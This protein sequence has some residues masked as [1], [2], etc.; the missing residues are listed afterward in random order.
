[1]A[2]NVPKSGGTEHNLAY[3]LVGRFMFY[4]AMLESSLNSG[5]E[6]LLMLGTLEGAI[7]TANLQF[8]SKIHILKTLMHL[9]CVE[10]DWRSDALS[11]L[12]R[13][14]TVN[15]HWRNTI[16]HVPFISAEDGVQFLRVKAKGKLDFPHTHWTRADFDNMR[17]EVI[18]LTDRVDE[19]V[20]A[21]AKQQRKPTL[22]DLAALATELQNEQEFPNYLGRLAPAPPGSQP[23]NPETAPETPQEPRGE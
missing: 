23:S 15:D 16:A 4:W 3:W 14:G 18:G 17:A 13:I 7:V 22:S 21:L 12:E 19:I 5:I 9:K 11:D 6:K 8:R 20:S 2:A 1:M 10:S